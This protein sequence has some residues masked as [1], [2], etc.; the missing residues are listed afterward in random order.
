[1]LVLVYVLAFAGS[2]LAASDPCPNAAYRVGPSAS[3]PDCRAYELVT[4]ADKGRTQD[5]VF[6]ES[7]D[8]AIPASDG[9]SIALETLVPLEP[10]L[11]VPASVV[12]ANAVSRV[13]RRAGR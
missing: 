3:L 10:S 6:R 5:M 7:T 11:S 4:P 2:A 13:P 1:M 8:K 9:E 12:G